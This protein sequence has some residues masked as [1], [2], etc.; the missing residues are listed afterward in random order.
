GVIAAL[1]GPA[2]HPRSAYTKSWWNNAPPSV[3]PPPPPPYLPPLAGEG[4]DGVALNR[5]RQAWSHPG[6]RRPPNSE[7]RSIPVNWE[8]LLLAYEFV[9]AGGTYGGH[10]AWLCRATGEIIWDTGNDVDEED[11]LDE[12]SDDFDDL[13][14]PSDDHE[15]AGHKTDD[16]IEGR[17]EDI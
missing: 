1:A 11:A 4:R 14:E 8:E 3:W 13:N 7:D 10:Y 2:L 6:S 9:N 17:P 16:D 5:A 15:S 12:S